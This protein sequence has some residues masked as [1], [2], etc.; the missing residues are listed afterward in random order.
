MGESVF[1]FENLSAELDC[2]VDLFNSIFTLMFLTQ[3]VSMKGRKLDQCVMV[4]ILRAFNDQTFCAGEIV[5]RLL[6]ICHFLVKLS[7]QDKHLGRKSFV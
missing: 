1:A 3:N 7:K 6:K 2:V 5:L 4:R